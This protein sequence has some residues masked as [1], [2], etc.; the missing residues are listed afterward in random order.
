MEKFVTI[1]I[2]KV[3]QDARIGSVFNELFTVINYTEATNTESI[4]WDFSDVTFLHPFFIAPL[5]LYKRNCGLDIK[6]SHINSQINDYFNLIHFEDIFDISSDEEIAVL[7]SYENKSY[8]PICSIDANADNI[9]QW[10]SFLQTIIQK[11]TRYGNRMT[12]PIAY[13]LSELICNVTQ[14]AKSKKAYLFSQYLEREQS[15]C[16][17]IADNGIGIYASYVETQKYLDIIGQ[18]EAIAL[19]M[20]NEGFSTKDLPDAENRGFGI[21]RTK[22]MLVKGLGGSFFMLSGSAFHRFNV[23]G[24]NYINLPKSINWNGT[25]VLLR[26]PLIPNKNFNFYNYI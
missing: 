11:Q 17:C 16:I 5:A 24:S 14:H 19:K 1:P 20:A 9:D 3:I 15:L 12:N 22:N 10:Q 25:I 4:I 23:Q 26:I 21:S 13:T 8:I 18:D 6:C 2:P 7:K